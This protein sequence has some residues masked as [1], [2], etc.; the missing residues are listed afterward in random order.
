LIKGLLSRFGFGKR[1]SEFSDIFA[2]TGV[3]SVTADNAMKVATVFA[4]VRLLS[5][6]IAT[7][8]LN[9]MQDYKGKKRHADNHPLYYLLRNKPNQDMNAVQLKEA[10]M[11]S[12]CLRGNGYLQKVQ[13]RGGQIVELPF[14]D[15]A[16]MSMQRLSN[17]SILYYYTSKTGKQ[18]TFTPDEIVNIP[19]FSLNG[20]EGVTPITMCRDGI[21]LAMTAEAHAKRFYENGGKPNAVLE[22]PATFSSDE[23]FKRLKDS[24]NTSFGGENSYKTAVLEGGATLKT[25]QMTAKDAEFIATRKFQKSEI[26]AMFNIPPH[27]I[28]DLEKATFSNIE[29]QSIEFEKFTIRPLVTKI[30]A[31][32][33]VSLLTENEQRQGYYFRFN[34]DALLRGDMKS[35]YDSYA[36]ARQWGFMNGNEIRE[37]EDM[38][39]FE[40]GDTYWMPVNMTDA[41]NPTNKGGTDGQKTT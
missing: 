15:A 9:L 2:R 40:G 6:T 24:F 12:M 33:N 17:G 39:S 31:A 32:L 36:V 35:R 19:Y 23:A 20:V 1:S 27:L 4:C 7:L 25:V 29:Q 14:L 11:A 8:P 34:T 28:G 10:L 5:E 26:A 21:G 13:T 37:L 22:I 41:A 16:R 30:E 38:E 18:Y 3:T